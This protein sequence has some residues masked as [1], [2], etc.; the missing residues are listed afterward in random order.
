MSDEASHDFRRESYSSLLICAPIFMAPAVLRQA[1]VKTAEIIVIGAGA[2]GLAA[3]RSLHDADMDVIVLEA[4]DRIGGRIWTVR[5][6]DVPIPIELGAEFVHGRAPGL[7]EL[8]TEAALSRM[9]INGHRFR[10]GARRLARFDDFWERLDG[11]MRRLNDLG[12]R[13][14]SFREFLATR[15][16]GRRLTAD[17]QLTARFVEGFHGADLKDISA[18]VLAQSG[19]PGDDVQER[20][21]GRVVNGYDSVLALLAEPVRTRVHLSS[22]VVTIQWDARGAILTVRQRQRQHQI[23]ARAAIVTVPV[24]VLQASPGRG[25]IRFEPELRQKADALAHMGSGS[26][27]RV[28]LHFQDRFWT[29]D[30]FTRR[31]RVDELD[32]L[33]FIHGTDRDFPTWWTAYPVIAPILVG[34]CG[35]PHAREMSVRPTAEIVDRALDA[36][37]RQLGES[38][39]RLRARLLGAW[40]HDWEGDPYA[41]GAYSYQLVGGANAPRQLARPLRQTLFFAGEASETSGATGTV[42][43]AIS[44]GR[45][46]ASQVLRSLGVR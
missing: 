46:A 8:L 21:L 20:R 35:G 10:A 16:G 30:Q 17:R 6:A 42:H 40:T 44:T 34:W 22:P 33:S 3:A 32:T 23:A 12:G 9:D 25:G 27:L 18:K 11:V 45:R 37:G 38:S 7:D 31:H 29:A 2:A 15:P 4:R 28:V 41:R 36:F 43:G 39:R 26:A 24:G 5:D 19:S 1:L 13:D 14:R